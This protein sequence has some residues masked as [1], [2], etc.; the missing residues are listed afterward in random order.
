MI[1]SRAVVAL[2]LFLFL[3]FGSSSVFGQ[4]QARRVMVFFDHAGPADEAYRRFFY[5]SL[6]VS[7]YSRNPRAQF[8]PADEASPASGEAAR[9]AAARRAGCDA[10]LEASIAATESAYEVALRAVDLY[11]GRTALELTYE[12][13]ANRGLRSLSL[14]LWDRAARAVGQAFAAA[15]EES[16]VRILGA[17]GTRLLG[18]TENPV[19]LET[20]EMRLMLAQPEIYRITAVSSRHYTQEVELFLGGRDSRLVLNQD[21]RSRFLVSAFGQ[22][23]SYFGLDLSYLLLPPHLFLRGG[24]YTY[25]FGVVPFAPRDE[26]GVPDGLIVSEPLSVFRLLVGSYWG[27]SH[28]WARFYTGAGPLARLV[29]STGYLGPEMVLPLGGEI[30]QGVELFP[31]K[32]L[33]FFVEYSPSLLIAF[34]RDAVAEMFDEF[35]GAEPIFLENDA[36]YVDLASFRAG[37]RFQ[38]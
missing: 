10:W 28:G 22:E 16:E 13:E 33:R 8:V 25:G 15:V 3:A 31:Q 18:L 5:E 27:H 24:F 21:E 2:L 20:P 30:V 7:L 37:I 19:T 12:V 14:R 32:K 1:R 36:G 29:V 23:L 6:L 11:N 38:W 4:E 34:E 17:P 35:P 26:S 9:S